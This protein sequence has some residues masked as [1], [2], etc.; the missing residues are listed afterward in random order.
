MSSTNKV[1]SL[2]AGEIIEQAL[3][4]SRIIPAAQPIDSTDYENGINSLNTVSK[5]WQTKGAHQWLIERAVLPL[6]VGQES[7]LLGPSGDPCGYRDGFVDTT[8]GTAIT[9]GATTIAVAST[10]GTESAPDILDSDPTDS[11]QDWTATNST[12]SISSGLRVTNS[13]AA[14]GYATYNL[15]ATVGQTYRVRVKYTLGTSSGVVLSVLNGTTVAS[16]VTLTS[17]STTTELAITASLDTITFKVANTSTTINQY[18]TVYD[19]QYVDD[20]TGSRI[21]IELDSGSMEWNYVLTVNS[22][23]SLL[24]TNAVGGNAAADN[25]VFGFTDQIDRPLRLSDMMFNANTSSSGVPVNKWSRQEYMQ[26]PL[27][28]GQGTVIN[29]Y[30]NPTLTNGTLYLW[31]TASNVSNTVE[32]DVRK[33]IT[34]YT[35]VS[36]ELEYPSEWFLPLKW[37][38]AA[39]LGPLYGIKQD[40]QTILEQ[41]ALDTFESTLGADNEDN[42]M[43][44]APDWS[45]R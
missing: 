7:Y 39:D 17:S 9:A 4:D 34:I 26:Q 14:A 16:T 37:A 10:T 40:R 21:G 41:K 12:L 33:P 25:L 43:Y 42:S 11:T 24:L 30:Y 28:S 27:K 31:Q 19:L 15:D 32:F 2:T 23:T 1:Y 13:G 3:R 22:S 44:I 8:V 38:I 5:F 6:N 45:G 29:W 36:D 20:E 35:D 18:S